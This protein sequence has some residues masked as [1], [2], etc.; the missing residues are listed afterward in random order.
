ME[1]YNMLSESGTNLRQPVGLENQLL[2]N[3]RMDSDVGK[4]MLQLLQV[5][6]LAL[7]LPAPQLKAYGTHATQSCK[8]R[9]FVVTGITA[10]S[11]PTAGCVGP[12][13]HAHLY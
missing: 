10:P 3:Q 4:S 7:A 2:K 12:H 11:T 9:F 8:V 13:I 1:L 6:L 5:L